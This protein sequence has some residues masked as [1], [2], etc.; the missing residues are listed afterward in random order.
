MPTVAYLP[1]WGI[2]SARDRR[3]L[4]HALPPHGLLPSAGSTLKRIFRKQCISRQADLVPSPAP[5]VW[6]ARPV[7]ASG[8]FLQTCKCLFPGTVRPAKATRV[9]RGGSYVRKSLDPS[10]ALRSTMCCVGALLP[11]LL[12]GCGG[13]DAD[14]VAP[15]ANQVACP[16][17]WNTSTFFRTVTPA[18]IAACL[19]AGESIRAK[20]T[21]GETPLH[22]AASY[23]TRDAAS[24]GRI[25]L[26][27]SGSYPRSRPCRRAVG[28][29][30]I[31]SGS[32]R[33]FL[34]PGI[35]D[36]GKSDYLS[37]GDV[38]LRSFH[39]YEPL[40]RR[41]LGRTVISVVYLMASPSWG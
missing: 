28:Q 9:H 38:A 12:A 18:Q 35:P 41:D 6:E 30:R 24:L 7:Y 19:D 5:P 26:G 20:T 31:V 17:G 13:G 16:A 37:I 1:Y 8:I 4:A 23:S 15:D 10:A 25:L 22:L 29:V 3:P 21:D 34:S 2:L 36:C 33:A 11:G 27:R 40:S 32:S 14:T 39:G